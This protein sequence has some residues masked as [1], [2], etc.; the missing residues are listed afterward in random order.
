[1][2]FFHQKK[3]FGDEVGQVWK[4]VVGQKNN[5]GGQKLQVWKRTSGGKKWQNTSRRKVLQTPTSIF[6]S[7]FIVKWLQHKWRLGKQKILKLC[8]NYWISLRTMFFY[9][10]QSPQVH[11]HQLWRKITIWGKCG[12]KNQLMVE[13]VVKCCAVNSWCMKLLWNVARQTF[14]GWSCYDKLLW[15]WVGGF[16]AKL[17]RPPA[18]CYIVS[19]T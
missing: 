5:F 11:L 13:V 3:Q 2:Y 9:E 7:F 10:G 19:F 6:S 14:D 17:G 12:L 8:K 16:A 15:L 4:Q 1:M 18:S